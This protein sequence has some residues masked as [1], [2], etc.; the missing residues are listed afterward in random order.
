MHS[1]LLHYLLI[2][3]PLGYVLVFISMIIEGDISLF[4]TAFLTRLG[5]FD[6]FDIIFFILAGAIVGDSLWYW[7]GRRLSN[8]SLWLIRYAAKV[9]S[10]FDRSIQE[11]NFRTLLIS[12]LTYGI[13]HL[14][15]IRTGMLRVPYKDFL[16]NDFLAILIWVAVIGGVGYL[17]GASY[18]LIRRYLKFVEVG[19]LLI[20]VIF[21]LFDKLLAKRLKDKI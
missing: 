12:K 2:W 18:L 16:R 5:Y 4:T 9:V 11:R 10:P 8:S 14:T 19:L 6:F 20:I 3:R 17:F 15:L 13:H 1:F 7:L 21:V